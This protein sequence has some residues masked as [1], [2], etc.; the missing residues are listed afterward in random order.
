MDNFTTIFIIGML[1]FIGYMYIDNNNNEVAYVV[2]GF[3]NQKY[4]VRNLS[5]NGDAADLLARTKGKLLKLCEYLKENYENKD[6]ISQLLDRFNPNS[7]TEAGKNTKYTSYSVNKGE[8]IVLCLRSRDEQE[9]LIDDNT[10][11]FVALHELAHIMTKS[12]GHTK[13]FWRNFKFLLK[14]AIELN[15]YQNEDYNSQPKPYCGIMV[16]DTPMNDSSIKVE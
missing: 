10:L 9:Q 11:M 16:S 3:D 14:R 1:M 4:L 6:G 12:I 2:S 13:E 15:I 5:D 7:I 8:K